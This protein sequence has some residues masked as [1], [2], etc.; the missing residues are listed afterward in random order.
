MTTPGPEGT[1]PEPAPSLPAGPGVDVAAET[2]TTDP[3]ANSVRRLYGQVSHWTAPRWQTAVDAP[4]AGALTRAD[5]V[6]DLVQ[7]LADLAAEAEGLPRR[8]V[9][10]TDGDVS[11][12]DQLRV[13]SADLVAAAP[14]PRVIAVAAEAVDSVRRQLVAT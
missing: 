9:P 10:R 3:L 4:G 7:R 8:A 1:T 13:V 2:S 14:P 6:H 11:L 5:L 12:P